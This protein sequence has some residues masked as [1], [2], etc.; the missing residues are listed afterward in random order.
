MESKH[1]VSTGAS[2]QLLLLYS[3]AEPMRTKNINV[4]SKHSVSTGASIQLPSVKVI[5]NDVENTPMGSS[6]LVAWA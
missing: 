6:K 3:Q 1:S 4:E 2:I 5:E